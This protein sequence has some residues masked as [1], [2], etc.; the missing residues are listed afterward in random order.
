[1]SQKRSY[2]QYP[3]EFKNKAVALV[4]DWGVQCQIAKSLRISTNILYRWKEQQIT[5]KT[6]VEDGREELK[7]LRKKNKE[8]RMEKVILKI[9][10]CLLR[11]RH[12]V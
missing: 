3:K 7:R 5:G 11:E 9:G 12:E 6:L 8:L 4:L 1:M 10:L 2:K